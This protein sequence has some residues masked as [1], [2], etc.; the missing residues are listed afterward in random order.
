MLSLLAL[1]APSDAFPTLAH[2]EHLAGGDRN[3]PTLSLGSVDAKEARASFSY[4]DNL[5]DGE[6]EDAV[7]AR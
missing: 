3:N 5:V 7:H 4:A 1:A 6:I 2:L